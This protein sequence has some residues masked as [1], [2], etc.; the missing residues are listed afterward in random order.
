MGLT[1]W[2][3]GWWGFA[4]PAEAA[5]QR[6]PEIWRIIR[7]HPGGHPGGL[8]GAWFRSSYLGLLRPIR[9]PGLARGL[10]LGLNPARPPPG[11]LPVHSWKCTA[12]VG[13]G[14]SRCGWPRRRLAHDCPLSMVLNTQPGAPGAHLSRTLRWRRSRHSQCRLGEEASSTP[15]SG[16]SRSG[17]AL[18][19][20]LTTLLPGLGRGTAGGQISLG[21]LVGTREW[22]QP[23]L[24]LG[25]S[26]SPP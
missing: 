6:S 21:D 3:W 1:R 10:H 12:R 13:G 18:G 20:N 23:G 14:E 19:E 5:L 22:P 9:G 25:H 16:S 8:A 4:V 17:L 15:A 11:R 7:S 26:L 2:R 24:V